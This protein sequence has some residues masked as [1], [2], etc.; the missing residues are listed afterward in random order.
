M[1]LSLQPTEYSYFDV[2]A[3]VTWAGPKH[4]KLKAK[5]QGDILL[6]MLLNL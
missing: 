2:A 4:W 6:F 3:M 5:T 1:Q